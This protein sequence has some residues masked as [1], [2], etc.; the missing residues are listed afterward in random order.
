MSEFLVLDTDRDLFGG[1]KGEKFRLLLKYCFD[2]AD[3][4]SLSKWDRPSYSN[5]VEDMLEPYCIDKVKVTRWFAY[6]GADT[7][8]EMIYETSEETLKIV[9]EYYQDVFLENRKRVP[10]KKY[11]Q[12]GKQ[13]LYP[14]ILEDMCFFKNKQMILGT[15]SHEYICVARCISHDFEHKLLSI[16]PWKRTDVDVYNVNMKYF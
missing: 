15:L 9:S 7:I 4:F 1:L 5:Y 12:I 6:N 13:Y 14:S 11:E 8:A 2:E 10:K 3:C 16:A